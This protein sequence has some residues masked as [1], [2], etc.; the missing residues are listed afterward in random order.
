MTDK[1]LEERTNDKLAS[2]ETLL[3][4]ANS[5]KMNISWS[6]P[7]DHFRALYAQNQALYEQNQIIIDYLRE[8]YK[9]MKK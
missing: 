2:I 7:Q 3:K 6:K 5:V 8:M 4:T 9:E 1:S